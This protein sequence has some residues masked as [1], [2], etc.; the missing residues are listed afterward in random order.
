[1]PPFEAMVRQLE[2]LLQGSCYEIIATNH[3]LS[4]HGDEETHGW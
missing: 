3:D 1:M 2:L 4:Q